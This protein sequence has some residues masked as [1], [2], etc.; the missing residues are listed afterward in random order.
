MAEAAIQTSFDACDSRDGKLKD[1]ILSLINISNENEIRL[2]E[3]RGDAS[4][5]R[6]DRATETT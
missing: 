2:R 1:A 6:P 4:R 5:D 3:L